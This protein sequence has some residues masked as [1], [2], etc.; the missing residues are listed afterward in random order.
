MPWELVPIVDRCLC[1]R[2]HIRAERI[3]TIK[4]HVVL[5]IFKQGLPD[6]PA[7]VEHSDKGS[8]V[9]FAGGKF[10]N[11]GHRFWQVRLR[12]FLLNWHCNSRH[13]QGAMIRAM[14]EDERL[15]FIRSLISD[16]VESPSLRHIREPRFVDKLAKEILRVVNRGPGPWEKWCGAREALLTASATT[17]IPAEDLRDYFNR[18]PGPELTTTDVAQRLRAIQEEGY[19]LYPSDALRDACMELYRKE[20]DAGTEMTAIIGAVEEFALQETERMRIERERAWKENQAAEREAL[21]QRLLSGADCKWTPLAKSNE[22]FCRMNGRLYRLSQG[23]NKRWKLHR[24]ETVNDEK[25][26]LVG[27]YTNRADATKVVAKMAYDPEL[28]W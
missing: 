10:R 28:R 27:Q 1:C 22:V 7:P 2:K 12:K 13:L 15:Y 3:Q 21:K 6:T 19:G 14:A 5:P 9:K 8:A 17:W 16:Y 11:I 4:F 20:L 23:E 26:H 25:G 24:V 18:M